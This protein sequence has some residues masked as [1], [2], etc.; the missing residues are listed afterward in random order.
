M[1][2]LT[3]LMEYLVKAAGEHAG[4]AVDKVGA[5]FLSGAAK[6]GTFQR[7]R[8]FAKTPE[9]LAAQFDW[10]APQAGR[11]SDV[12]TFLDPNDPAT[13]TVMFGNSLDD[14]KRYDAMLRKNKEGSVY[15]PFLERGDLPPDATYWGFG[16]SE[17][18][19]G[20]GAG[21]RAYPAMYGNVLSDPNAYNIKGGLTSSNAYRNNYA[22]AN[23][24]MR[25]PK[26]GERLL[27]SPEQFQHLAVNPAE[28]RHSGAERQVGALQTEGALQTLQRLSAGF[29]KTG[30][31]ALRQKLLDLTDSLG[32]NISPADL[33]D[34]VNAVRAGA[35]TNPTDLGSIGPGALKKLGIVQDVVNGRPVD[36][37]VY[38]GLEFSSGGAVPVNPGG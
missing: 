33:Q 32:S 1:S 12:K 18:S 11:S 35:L 19:R 13:K 20:S 10:S 16:T 5:E 38:R 15:A 27:A 21:T 36:P 4:T 31:M 25:D 23:A 8:E 14:L 9:G 28:L 7:G 3:E 2:V 37:R 17:L 26:A 6:Q 24:I 22:L 30:N 34:A 29:D